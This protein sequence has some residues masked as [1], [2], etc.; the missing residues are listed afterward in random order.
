MQNTGE[1]EQSPNQETQSKLT[2]G[3]WQSFLLTLAGAAGLIS[4]VA[5]G[6]LWLTYL[7][8][9]STIILLLW[10]IFDLA[11]KKS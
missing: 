7:G 2:L 1:S 9:G 5:N 8:F 4:M 11:K 3:F 10:I 6:P